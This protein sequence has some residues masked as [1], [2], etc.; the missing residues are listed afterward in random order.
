MLKAYKYRIYPD[1]G[2]EELLS[3]TFGCVRFVYN[4]Y[5]E[6]KRLCY[7]DGQKSPSKTD[8]NNDLNRVLK[9][10]YP[11]L[12]EVDKFALT[13]AVFHLDT[14]YQKFFR[15]K[16][17]YPK[18]KSKHSHYDSYT[19]NF[20]NG[21]IKALFGEDRIQLPKLGKIRAK[22]HRSFEGKIK[23]AVVSRNPSGR[24]FVSILVEVTE[25]EPLP[26]NEKRLGIDMGLK[27]FLVDSNGHHI[28]NPRPLAVYE[29]K[30]AKEQRKLSHKKIGGRN[31]EK[32]RRKTA[33]IHET[34]RNIRTD[35]TNQLSSKLVEENQILISEKLAIRNMIKTHHLAKSIA[36]AGWGEFLRKV[37]YKAKWRGR[38]FHRI[39]AWYASSQIC[40][41]CGKKNP[42][43][44][45]LSVRSWE[46]SCGAVHQRDEN[47]AK[48]ILRKGL[49][50][51]RE[52]S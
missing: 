22:L 18:F 10:E 52:A 29:R 13:N 23:S 49:E 45:L 27:E 40:S 34:I 26:P 25:E 12:R 48:N 2:Q 46:C 32:Q 7:E 1:R 37:E 4:H 5:L 47:A 51:L 36:D 44:K 11:W 15:E 31:W 50:E 28:A 3:K 8:C 19:T 41:S 9:A 42:E 39:D 20:T 35:F 6:K 16:T 21:N 24:Y 43:V 17:G 14:A 38:T 30:L 33:R